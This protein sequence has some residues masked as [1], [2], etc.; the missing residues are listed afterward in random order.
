MWLM[1]RRCK[2]HV[3]LLSAALQCQTSSKWQWSP[4]AWHVHQNMLVLTVGQNQNPWPFG[5]HSSLSGQ[6]ARFQICLWQHKN[7]KALRVDNAS[8]NQLP[9]WVMQGASAW[10]R[11]ATQP[12]GQSQI[13]LDVL[14]LHG[15]GVT[16][17]R[18]L[19]FEIWP[20]ALRLGPAS[21]W[22]AFS[23]FVEHIVTPWYKDT[24]YQGHSHWKHYE[25]G[26]T[27]L[28]FDHRHR[29]LSQGNL[30]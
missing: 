3:A 30:M 8:W 19:N 5:S 11:E 12:Q 17:V 13:Y 4:W 25:I 24:R 9:L 28:R 16:V 23:Q 27:S 15:E 6:A 20:D 1:A 14:N 10:S 7:W 21:K 29:Y 22:P 18:G 26:N 2:G